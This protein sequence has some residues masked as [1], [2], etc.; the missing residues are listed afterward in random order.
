MNKINEGKLHSKSRWDQRSRR[1]S[2]TCLVSHEF[3]KYLAFET[4]KNE[5]PGGTL[6]FRREHYDM[7]TWSFL[8][9]VLHNVNTLFEN[10]LHG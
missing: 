4:A 10:N 7:S 9:V 2:F 6:A 5:W 3:E 1:N 8:S